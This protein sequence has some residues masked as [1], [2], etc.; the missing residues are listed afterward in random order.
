MTPIGQIRKKV[1]IPY[2]DEQPKLRAWYKYVA[3]IGT[4]CGTIIWADKS[5]LNV[6]DW[7]YFGDISD[8]DLENPKRWNVYPSETVVRKGCV[9]MINAEPRAF[10]SL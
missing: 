1:C 6:G 10:I 3:K 4:T 9:T 8:F 7:V 5:E 2:K